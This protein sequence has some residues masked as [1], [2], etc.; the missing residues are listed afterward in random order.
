MAKRKTT[1]MVEVEFDDEHTD[2]ESLMEMLDVLIITA[3]G[4]PGILDDYNPV[5]I[6]EF[7]FI[8]RKRIK[9]TIAD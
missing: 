9:K 8:P 1:F 7:S 4:Q 6:G 2:D 3:T 5:S